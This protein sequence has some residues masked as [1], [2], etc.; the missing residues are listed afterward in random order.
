YIYEGLL[1]YTCRRVTGVQVGLVGAPGAEPEIPLAVL[2][3]LARRHP[4]PAALAGAVLAWLK[5]DQPAAKP[6]SVNA[7]AKLLGAA[8]TEDD[9]RQLRAVTGGDDALRER[10]RRFA[11]AVRRDLRD[12]P[13]VLLDGGLLVVETPSRR[14]AGAHYTPRS[15][16]EEVV[17]HALEPLC[18]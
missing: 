14:N 11:P 16:A 2:E 17:Q 5:E 15:L 3:E 13:T 10:L 7:L 6:P 12:R 18:Y 8:P 4:A 1:G 9:D